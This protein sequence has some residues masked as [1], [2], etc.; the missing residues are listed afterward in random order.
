[1]CVTPVATI[2]KRETLSIF[3]LNLDVFNKTN[4]CLCGPWKKIY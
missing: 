1:M 3:R 4:M 2:D